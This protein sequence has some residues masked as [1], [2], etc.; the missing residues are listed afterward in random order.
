MVSVRV[1]PVEPADLP[2]LVHLQELA[3]QGV[4]EGRLVRLLHER[5]KAIV[6][7]AATVE[8][9][10]AG[11][12]LFSPVSFRPEYP[13]IR[14][15][16][17]APLAVLPEYQNQGIGSLLMR[18]GLRHCQASGWQVVV[19]L[20]HPTYYPRFGFQPAKNFGLGNE[21]GAEEA[22]MALELAPHA[23]EGIQAVACYAEEFN[24]IGV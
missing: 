6:S 9:R 17:L 12:I 24:E 10:I 23:L 2:E 20:G 16:G 4:D 7:L 21:Y 14:A 11:H 5:G 19:V 8:E 3:F 22:F 13:A 18:E 1:R 15:L